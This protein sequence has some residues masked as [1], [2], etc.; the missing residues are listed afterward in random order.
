MIGFCMKT[1]RINASLLETFEAECRKRE[2]ITGYIKPNL[3][4][5]VE[6]ALE[7]HMEEYFKDF[8]I[9]YHERR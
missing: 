3:N 7:L 5:F 2:D 9:I 8:P 4:D 1:V 6:T